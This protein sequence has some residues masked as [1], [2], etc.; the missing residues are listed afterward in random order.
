MVGN[1]GAQRDAIVRGHHHELLSQGLDVSGGVEELRMEVMGLLTGFLKVEKLRYHRHE[2][3]AILCGHVKELPAAAAQ[4]LV[5]GNVLQRCQNK[6]QR[7]ADVVGGVDEE[8]DFL[9][10]VALLQ[11]VA[12][13]IPP[14]IDYPQQQ[15]R[16]DHPRPEGIPPWLCDGDAQGRGA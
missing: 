12:V 15:G 13:V 5:G 10:V 9:L 7:R 2:P 11:A 14:H 4:P 3:V 16:V 6:G 8:V 1:V